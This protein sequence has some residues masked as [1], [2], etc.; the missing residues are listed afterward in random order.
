M[1]LLAARDVI[2]IG[3]TRLKNNQRALCNEFCYCRQCSDKPAAWIE[4][5]SHYGEATRDEKVSG[6]LAYQE[7]RSSVNR[8]EG[9]RSL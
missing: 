8:D 1:K 5:D 7:T 4:L 9:T 2:F 3:K 6:L